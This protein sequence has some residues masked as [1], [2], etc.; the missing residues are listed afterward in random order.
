MGI[1]VIKRRYLCQSFNRAS[2]TSN[3]QG[4]Y[5]NFTVEIPI[6]AHM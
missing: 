5:T 4:L 6:S 1:C 2:N 3:L